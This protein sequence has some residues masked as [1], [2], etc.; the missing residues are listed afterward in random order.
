VT[1]LSKGCIGRDLRAPK[2]CFRPVFIAGN[3]NLQSKLKINNK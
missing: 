2:G 3:Y 1:P